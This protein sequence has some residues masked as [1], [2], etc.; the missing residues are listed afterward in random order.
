MKLLA[1]LFLAAGFFLQSCG[2]TGPVEGSHILLGTPDITT[3]DFFLLS[4]REHSLVI[5]PYN[6]DYFH[7]DAVIASAFSV[8]YE[9]V[10]HL[11]QVAPFNAG[12]IAGATGAGLLGGMY[13]GNLVRPVTDAEY[14]AGARTLVFAKETYIGMATGAVF[15]AAMGYLFYQKKSVIYHVDRAE[16]RVKLRHVAIYHEEEPPELAKI[17]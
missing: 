9:K 10:T 13:I 11:E 1:L 8:P 14:D 16:D 5:A 17:K 7:I 3:Q 15:G 12:P 2:T 6:T 4:M